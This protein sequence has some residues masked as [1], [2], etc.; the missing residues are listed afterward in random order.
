MSV[1]KFFLKDCVAVHLRNVRKL[2]KANDCY[3]LGGSPTLHIT[4]YLRNF[5]AGFGLCF[6]NTV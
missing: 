6:V 5:A 4:R 2:T 1:S 3:P